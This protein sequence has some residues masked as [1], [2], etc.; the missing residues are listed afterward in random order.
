MYLTV[1]A[2]KGFLLCCSRIS[3]YTGIFSWVVTDTL[4]NVW[5]L[6]KVVHH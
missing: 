6:N 3:T 1:S 4:V 5:L 2:V